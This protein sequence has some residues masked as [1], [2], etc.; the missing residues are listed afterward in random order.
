MGAELQKTNKVWRQPTMRLTSVTTT[1][2]DKTVAVSCVYEMPE[3]QATLTLIYNIMPD[4]SLLVD[5]RMK[6][7][8]GAKMPDLPRFGMMLQLPL[9]MQKSRYYGRGPVENYADRKGSQRIGVYEQTVDEQFYPYIRP[10]ETGTKGDMRWWQQ[11]RAD[12]R[13]WM[14][15][16]DT[17]FYASALPYDLE[18]L[19]EG[20]TKHQRHPADLRLSAFV[21]IFIDAVHTGLGGI[22]SWTRQGQALGHYR[23]QYKDYKLRFLISPIR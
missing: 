14:I 7:T 12:G 8:P 5:Q 13:G 4:G 22:D 1:N 2:K 23:L 15:S 19:D 18:E 17:P 9:A 16:S 10:Q 3:V 6:T 11:L 20:D 21:N